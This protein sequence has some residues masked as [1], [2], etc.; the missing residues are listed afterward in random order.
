M[1]QALGPG[2]LSEKEGTDP[3]GRGVDRPYPSI[4]TQKIVFFK[5]KLK[6][7][8]G[9]SEG[10]VF[11]LVNRVQGVVTSRNASAWGEGGGSL[12]SKPRPRRT[13]RR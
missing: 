12:V 4:L 11:P 6:A 7:K 13:R 9:K 1:T 3:L 2:E 8:L 10:E 5:I